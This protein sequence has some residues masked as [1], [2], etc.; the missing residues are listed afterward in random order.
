MRAG[1]RDTNT[2]YSFRPS[3]D[4][5][6]GPMTVTVEVMFVLGCISAVQVKDTAVGKV[7]TQERLLLQA[8]C[9]AAGLWK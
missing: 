2:G 5:S 8:A 9:S 7:L 4:A 1:V 3:I 6:S